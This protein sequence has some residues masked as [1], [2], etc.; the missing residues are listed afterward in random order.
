MNGLLSDRNWQAGS[1]PYDWS[2]LVPNHE[3][4]NRRAA[5]R[6]RK[7]PRKKKEWCQILLFSKSSPGFFG[8]GRHYTANALITI[9]KAGDLEADRSKA[10]S[11]I[12]AWRRKPGGPAPIFSIYLTVQR[13]LVSQVASHV[14]NVLVS[15]RDQFPPELSGFQIEVAIFDESLLQHLDLKVFPALHSGD[16]DSTG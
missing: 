12:A 3:A 4:C 10:M 6:F 13:H 9:E 16:P 5:I 2:S 7:T 14:V 11:E 1:A 15:N 8:F